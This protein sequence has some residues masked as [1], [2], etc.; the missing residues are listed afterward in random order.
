VLFRSLFATSHLSSALPHRRVRFGAPSSQ[1]HHPRHHGQ[2]LRRLG[3]HLS[4]SLP[5]RCRPSR[6][7]PQDRFVCAAGSLARDSALTF[8]SRSLAGFIFFGLGVFCSLCVYF[9]IPGK[10]SIEGSNAPTFKADPSP[11]QTSPADPSPR[12]TSCLLA[13][14]RLASLP[15][16]PR[17]GS[18]VMIWSLARMTRVVRSSEGAGKGNRSLWQDIYRLQRNLYKGS[19]LSH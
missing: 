1:N 11:V 2:C 3:L 6:P 12:L 14:S 17:L 10:S 19:K 16:P 9:F 4:S 18:T 7:R 15:R 5:S 8:A 13:A